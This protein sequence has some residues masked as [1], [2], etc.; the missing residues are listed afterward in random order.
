MNTVYSDDEIIEFVEAEILPYCN[1]NRI[2]ETICGIAEELFNANNIIP[3]VDNANPVDSFYFLIILTL[4]NLT[5]L[6]STIDCYCNAIARKGIYRKF[7]VLDVL[8]NIIIMMAT[9]LKTYENF[10]NDGYRNLEVFNEQQ[11]KIIL[12]L[13]INIIFTFITLYFSIISLPS[14]MVTTW[15]NTSNHKTILRIFISIISIMELVIQEIGFRIIRK[16]FRISHGTLETPFHKRF[17]VS[18]LQPE[19]DS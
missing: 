6:L 9:F 11:G 12:F 5:L 8:C 7:L 1:C 16:R 3:V 19:P 10:N 15:V 13:I 18:S 2:S 17:S 4:I 14:T